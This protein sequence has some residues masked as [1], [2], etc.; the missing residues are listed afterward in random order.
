MQ[1]R[2]AR[3]AGVTYFFTVNLAERHRSL[4]VDSIAI[5]RKVVATVKCFKRGRSAMK[6]SCIALD[7]FG[8]SHIQK[9]GH[10]LVLAVRQL[11]RIPGQILHCSPLAEACA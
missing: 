6:R 11:E 8:P 10:S 7:S 5:L 4:L 3:F 9:S 2:R 1:Y